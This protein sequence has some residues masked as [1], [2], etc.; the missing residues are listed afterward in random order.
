ME[1][2]SLFVLVLGEYI[3]HLLAVSCSW[4]LVLQ[5]AGKLF[6]SV[7][8]ESTKTFFPHLPVL[9]FDNR[10]FSFV[11]AFVMPSF[12]SDYADDSSLLCTSMY[13]SAVYH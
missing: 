5:C 12:D 9:H 7:L 3:F 8:S 4:F 11:I 2:E 6:P 13:S 1:L 10:S